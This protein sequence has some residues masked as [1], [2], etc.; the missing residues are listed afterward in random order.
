MKPLTNERPFFYSP[1]QLDDIAAKLPYAAVAEVEVVEV[2]QRGGAGSGHFGHEGRPG[3]RGGSAPGEGGGTPTGGGG[4]S[5]T[6]LAER[7]RG[8]AT[9]IEPGVTRMLSGLASETGGRMHNLDRAVKSYEALASKIERNAESMGITVEQAA[10][11]V[12]DALR[13]TMVFPTDHFVDEV[14]AVQDALS[15][16]GWDE[17]D[18]TWKNY[19]AP[20]DAYDGY[21]TVLVHRDTG[22]RFE[23]QFHT[24]QTADTKEQVHVLY[25]QYRTSTDRDERVE[26]WGR[27]TAMWREE[28]K[29][30]GWERLRGL[31]MSEAAAP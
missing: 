17:W 6:V 11:D 24:P 20:G 14:V 25:D 2:V 5:A 7:R 10:A 19:F 30:V 29:P 21:N 12:N 18:T 31:V 8:H 22:E 4:R 23:L 13:Y 15:E 3:E 16:A 27:M 28:D 26:L 1:E 9:R